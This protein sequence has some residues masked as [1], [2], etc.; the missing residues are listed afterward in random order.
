MKVPRGDLFFLGEDRLNSNDARFGL[1]FVP[2]DKVIGLARAIV[3]PPS[4]V[5]WID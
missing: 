1:G 2:Q 4:R 5:G 3:R